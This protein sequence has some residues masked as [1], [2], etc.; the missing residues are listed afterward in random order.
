MPNYV[1]ICRASSTKGALAKVDVGLRYANSI[2][3]NLTNTFDCTLDKVQAGEEIV[4]TQRGK[5]VTRKLF[6]PINASV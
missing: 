2:N 5:A 3:E 1:S 4:I 6:G